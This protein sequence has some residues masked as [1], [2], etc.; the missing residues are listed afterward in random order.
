MDDLAR[1]LVAAAIGLAA[2]LGAQPADASLKA[3][4]GP[5]T[6]PDGSSA[7]PVYQ[8]LGVDVLEEQIQWD[9]VAPTRPADP[10][11]PNDPAYRWPADVQAA[12]DG[13]G[14]TGMRVLIMVK[15]SPGWANGGQSPA[16]APDQ[17]GDF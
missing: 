2:L 4:W 15:H 6:M 9:Q 12:V 7:F 10:T 1:I 16:W 17:P 14:A 5:N 8:R 11:N 13:A 3:I